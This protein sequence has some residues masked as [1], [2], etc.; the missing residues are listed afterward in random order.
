[1]KQVMQN[2]K[3]LM[4]TGMTDVLA[5]A[6]IGGFEVFWQ[7]GKPALNFTDNTKSIDFNGVDRE[8]HAV[9]SLNNWNGITYAWKSTEKSGDKFIFTKAKAFE[10]GLHAGS[11]GMMK[12]GSLVHV[13]DQEPTAKKETNKPSF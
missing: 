10:A 2:N 11:I 3:D 5:Q 7:F 9:L 13:L 6:S 1:M 8:A 4:A 12:D